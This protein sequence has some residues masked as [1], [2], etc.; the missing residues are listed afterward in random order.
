MVVM[1]VALIVAS[2]ALAEQDEEA[3]VMPSAELLEY[4]GQLVEME[5]ELIGPEYFDIDDE[6]VQADKADED[7][8]TGADKTPNEGRDFH[9]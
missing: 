3:E 1:V 8:A 5:D 2:T 7:L 4:L 9:E 6:D